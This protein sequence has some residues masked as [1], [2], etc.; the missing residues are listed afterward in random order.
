MKRYTGRGYLQLTGRQNALGT[1]LHEIMASEIQK[2]IDAEII[3]E[4][5][6]EDKKHWHQVELKWEKGK[7]T[8][9]FWNEACA[10]AVEQFGLPG[11]K[12]VTHPTADNMLFLFKNESDAILMTLKWI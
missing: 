5:M 11:D 1:A 8:Q 9:Y 7:D 10:W 12:Y 4:I 6:K 2:E 3:W